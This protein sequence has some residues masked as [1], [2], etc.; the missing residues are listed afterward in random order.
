MTTEEY[1]DR[2]DDINVAYANVVE[3]MKSFMTRLYGVADSAGIEN[4]TLMSPDELLTELNKRVIMLN[5]K[6]LAEIRDAR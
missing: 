3:D 4:P 6:D 5:R 1:K 2:I